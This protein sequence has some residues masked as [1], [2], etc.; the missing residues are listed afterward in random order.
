MCWKVS[1]HP[2]INIPKLVL[3]SDS[4]THV[5]FKILWEDDVVCMCVFCLCMCLCSLLQTGSFHVMFLYVDNFVCN[6]LHAHFGEHLMLYQ[7]IT[8]IRLFKVTLNIERLTVSVVFSLQRPCTCLG[9]GTAHRTWLTSG[10]TA[11][12][13]TSGPASPE[14][15]RKRCVWDQKYFD[16]LLKYRYVLQKDTKTYQICSIHFM[17]EKF[18]ECS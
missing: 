18:W 7:S 5:F 13:R 17:S 15:L 16:I 14:T 4:L 8:L 6:W 3:R 2:R 10:L 12:R 9:A 11:F 1:F